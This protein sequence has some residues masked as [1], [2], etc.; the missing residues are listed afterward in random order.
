MKKTLVLGITVAVAVVHGA[1]MY[2]VRAFGAK[3]DG[4]TKD[5]VAVQRA[6]DACA[7][8]GGRVVVPPGTYL[9]GSI[10]LG[11]ATELHLEKGATLLG[12]P[13]LADYNMPDA[14][15]QNFGSVNEGWSA[16]HLI[17]AIEKHGVSITGRGTIDGNGRAFFADKPEFRGKVCWR[18]G[19]INA[20][21]RE[22]Q[23]RPGQEI[24]FIECRDVAVR[25][26]TFRDMSCWSCFFHGCENV[27]VGGVTVR[28]GMLNLNTDGFDVDSCRNVRIGDCDI[29]TGDDAIAIRGC[30]AKL[31]D[32]SK[33][34]ENVRVSNIVCRVSA[35][36]VR[37]GVGDG[38]I[39]DVRIS[40]MRIEHS[41]R[42]LHV[43]CCYGRQPKKGVDIS[44]VKF[45]RIAIRNTTQAI[46]VGAGSPH[47]KAKLGDVSFDRIDAES[48]LPFTVAGDGETR[49]HGVSF[50]NC[51]FWPVRSREGQVAD[52]EAGKL[53]GD[54]AGAIRIERADGISFSACALRWDGNADPG[55]T[56]AFSLHDAAVPSIDAAS[57][58]RDRPAQ[59]SGPFRR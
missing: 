50:A 29:V 41:G 44:D 46:L 34:C 59:S 52:R 5:T 31:K 7:E 56:R 27:T 51:T 9:I 19:G 55:V 43:Q 40:D 28:N 16:K 57:S 18:D 48:E 24:V 36:G 6:L 1:D 39:R 3:G 23:G 4:V 10:F 45:A 13:D 25:D 30:P 42:G 12:S 15:P 26:V 17:L 47:S 38:T 2:D 58:L 35:D 54:G 49:V 37:V 8:T 11:D 32:P 53:S 14:Y 33:V 22:H 21:D 20:K